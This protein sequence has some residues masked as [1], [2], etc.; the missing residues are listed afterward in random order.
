MNQVLEHMGGCDPASLVAC[1]A[2]ALDESTRY[3]SPSPSLR[4]FR[5]RCRRL[6]ATFCPLRFTTSSGSA[7]TVHT[8]VLLLTVAAVVVAGYY[9][10][11]ASGTT[12]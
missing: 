10:A 8:L 1:V 12:S 11:P 3:L 4:R 6:A 7:A 5:R 9:R 2:G